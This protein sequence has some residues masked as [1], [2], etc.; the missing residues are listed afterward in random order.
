MA[1]LV[2]VNVGLPRDVAWNDRVVHTGAWKTTVKPRTTAV[3]RAW[4]PGA[5]T[6]A[7]ELSLTRQVIVVRK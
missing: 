1:M 6:L 5:G 2:A 7:P 3:W 4:W